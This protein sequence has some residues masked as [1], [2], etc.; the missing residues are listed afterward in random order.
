VNRF[1]FFGLALL[2]AAALLGGTGEAS[3][4]G[5]PYKF[6]DEQRIDRRQ[7]GYTDVTVDRAGVATFTTKF[8]NGKQW[9]GDH[10]FARIVLRDAAGRPVA[11]VEQKKGLNGSF[12][13]KAREGSVTNKLRLTPGQWARVRS[14]KVEMG[15]YDA[16]DDAKVW[17][18]LR[19]LAEAWAQGGDEQYREAARPS[20][21]RL[22]GRT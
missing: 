1:S 12:G 22:D 4:V 7:Y 21:G 13:G 2:F 9:D 19:K 5:L 15:H 20:W 10:F 6:H 11:A 17:E 18:A 8:S 16:I 3:A 14:V